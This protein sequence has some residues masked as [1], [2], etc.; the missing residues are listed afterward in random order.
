MTIRQYQID[1]RDVH[2]IANDIL[3]A[4]NGR[5]VLM[6]EMALLMAFLEVAEGVREYPDETRLMRARIALER[7]SASI[8]QIIDEVGKLPDDEVIALAMPSAS[9]S[10]N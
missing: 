9:P 4:L 10:C 1:L 6:C 2:P 3:N 8:A 5:S 7:S